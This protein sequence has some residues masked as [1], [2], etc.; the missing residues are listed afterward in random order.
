MRKKVL[1][2]AAHPDDEVLGCGGTIAKFSDEGAD[3]HILFLADGVSSR[4]PK[5]SNKLINSSEARRQSA[6]IAADILGV[7]SLMFGDF[8]DNRMDSIGLL[9]IV[10]FI[11]NKINEFQPQILLTH[12]SSDL[13][14]DHRIVNQAV[15]TACRPQPDFFVETLLFFEVCSSTEWQIPTTFSPNWF[16]DIAKYLELRSKALEAYSA[17]LRAWPHS[18]SLKAINHLANWRG[19][20]IGVEAAEAF[21]L[22]RRVI[23]D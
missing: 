16:V 15:I 13:N 5:E 1:I 18:R 23:K 12:Y 14:I 11:E 4:D 2:C 22:G 19:A 21:M 9:E 7:K 20:S 3:V 8:P 17:E 6:Y 10:K